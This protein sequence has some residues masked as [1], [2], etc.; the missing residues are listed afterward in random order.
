MIEF[1]DGRAQ[2]PGES[3]SRLQLVRLG[4]ARPRLQVPVAGPHGQT[5]WVDFGLDD[6]DALG[7]FDGKG[8][9]LDEAMR[10][11]LS[12]EAVLLEEKK[13]EDWIRGRTQR[14]FARWSNEHLGTPELLAARLAAFGIRPPD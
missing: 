14:R 1:A 8:K 6:V 10:D 11:G 2:L 5:Y 9:Y 4:F 7:E 13:R 3:V 12:L